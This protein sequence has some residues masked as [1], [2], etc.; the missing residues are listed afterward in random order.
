MTLSM[1]CVAGSTMPAPNRRLLS[2]MVKKEID[3]QLGAELVVQ[4][5]KFNG[6]N[7]ER[8]SASKAGE[9]QASS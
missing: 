4:I 5:L 8:A 9:P 7:V 3:D 1:R 6:L 2:E